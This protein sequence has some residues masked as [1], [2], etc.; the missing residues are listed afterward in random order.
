[1]CLLQCL[2]L[3]GSCE[4]RVFFHLNKGHHSQILSGEV[5]VKLNI[6]SERRYGSCRLRQ[7][8]RHLPDIPACVY[9]WPYTAGARSLLNTCQKYLEMCSLRF[10]F[11]LDYVFRGCN[12]ICSQKFVLWYHPKTKRKCYHLHHHTQP[13]Y[14][15]I[16]AGKW[17]KVLNYLW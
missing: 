2:L 1:M 5:N 10:G 7:R 14:R 15:S 3:E 16:Q 11:A 9:I 13:L 8:L 6:N 17:K 12:L 4:M